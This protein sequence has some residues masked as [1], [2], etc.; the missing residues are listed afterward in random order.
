MLSV[1]P[2]PYAPIWFEAL[3]SRTLTRYGLN[4][5]V[6]RSELLAEPFF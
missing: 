6:Q 4:A 1:V 2:S 3:L 5:L